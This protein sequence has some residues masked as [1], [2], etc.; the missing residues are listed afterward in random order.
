MLSYSRQTDLK[1]I[2]CPTDTVEKYQKVSWW[3]FLLLPSPF[4]QRCIGNGS[5][6]VRQ[7]PRRAARIADADAPFP[8]R[9]APWFRWPKFDSFVTDGFTTF[10]VPQLDNNIRMPPS[11]LDSNPTV[12]TMRVK[13]HK[14]TVFDVTIKVA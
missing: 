8:T 12:Q 10:F 11:I 5:L 4:E 2:Y 6:L 7:R 3:I 14:W 1:R 9:E 13:P